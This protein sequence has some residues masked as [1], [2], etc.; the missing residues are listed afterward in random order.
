SILLPQRSYHFASQS[1]GFPSQHDGSQHGKFFHTGG[2]YEA[3]D[4]TGLS[5][6]GDVLL[7][8]HQNPLPIEEPVINPSLLS[9][10]GTGER[11]RAAVEPGQDG[12]HQPTVTTVR[13]P[14]AGASTSASNPVW[15]N[16]IN[17]LDHRDSRFLGITHRNADETTSQGTQRSQT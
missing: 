1:Q 10:S 4:T 8:E 2:M 13:V 11:G 7:L 17:R 14:F 3:S 6:N 5:L 12:Q 15:I 9:H 16:E